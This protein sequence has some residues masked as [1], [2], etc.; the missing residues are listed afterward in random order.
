VSDFRLDR[1]EITVGRF[2][3]FWEQYPADM[4]AGSSGIDSNDPTDPGWNPIWNGT[5]YLLPNASDLDTAVTECPTSAMWIDWTL[6]D[7]TLPMNCISWYEAYAFC[8]WDGG[9]LPTDLEW[10]YA[11][12]GGSDQ[13]PYPWSTSPTDMTIDST[14]AVYAPAASVYAPVGSDSPKGDGKWGQA[15]LAGNV[16][17]WVEDWKETYPVTCT[18]CASVDWSV[19]NYIPPGGGPYRQVRGGSAADDASFQLTSNPW[20]WNVPSYRID[21]VGARCARNPDGPASP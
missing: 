6:T 20:F 3:K 12:A 21:N 4:P 14:Y 17:E 13:R 5:G 8:I 19:A 11:A 7:D 16:M 2:R 18:D 10:N 9:R 15:D 1:F